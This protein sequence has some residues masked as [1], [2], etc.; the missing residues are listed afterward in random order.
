[1][2]IASLEVMSAKRYVYVL[3]TVSNS[4]VCGKKV[5]KQSSEKC[6]NK[7]FFSF[8]VGE[9]GNSPDGRRNLG[10]VVVSE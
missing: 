3:L 1:M 6:E 10:K 9:R 5:S 7:F 2:R 4:Y 8:G